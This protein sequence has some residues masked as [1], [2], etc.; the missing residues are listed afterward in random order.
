MRGKSRGEAR[1]VAIVAVGLL[2]AFAN[3]LLG[4][5]YGGGATEEETIVERL[6]KSYDAVSDFVA[7]FRQETEIKTLSRILKARGKVY[8]KRPGKMLWRYEEPPKQWVLADGNSLYLYQP[9]QSQ[10]LKSPLKA[11][12]RSDIPL[13]F[14]LGL[15]DL[16]RDFLVVLKGAEDGRYVLRLAPKGETGALSEIELGVD[17]K[18]FDVVWARIRDAVGNMTTI[19]FSNM[20]KGAGL[21]DSL[22]QPEI[23]D[24]VDVVE[25]GS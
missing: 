19:R 15:G 7:E 17:R 8:F 18:A 11:A 9:E 24:G 16:K 4:A 2:V 3:V 25:L 6:Q 22:F 21:K 10:I 5:R 13:S 20:K 23:P 14:L 12:F 1:F